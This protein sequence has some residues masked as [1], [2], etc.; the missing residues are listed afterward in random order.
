MTPS[1]AP[2]LASAAACTD[3]GSRSRAEVLRGALADDDVDD[4]DDGG[5]N[6]VVVAVVERRAHLAMLLPAV[7]HYVF[8]TRPLDLSFLCG[9]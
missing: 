8:E 2:V 3:G 9:D 5:G 6:V 7:Q 1:L 4:E